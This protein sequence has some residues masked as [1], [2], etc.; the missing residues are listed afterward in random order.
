MENRGAGLAAGEFDL[1]DGT[2]TAGAEAGGGACIILVKSPGPPPV[3][4]G[5]DGAEGMEGALKNA[6]AP[7]GVEG[8]LGLGT[9]GN[10]GNGG[11]EGTEGI[12]GAE[13]TPGK[14]FNEKLLPPTEA[15]GKEGALK[16]G[17]PEGGALTGGGLSGAAGTGGT[18][19]GFTFLN[20]VV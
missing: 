5:L 19:G 14:L 13:G 3:G 18:G 6:V 8:A 1:G 10:E 16:L 2:P 9:E 11:A 12:E 7:S 15:E 4:S 20:G 17:M